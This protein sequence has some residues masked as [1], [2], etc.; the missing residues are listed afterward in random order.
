[1]ALR[2]TI[3]DSGKFDG[4]STRVVTITPMRAIRLFC[5]ECMGGSYREIAGCADKWCPLYL[6]RTGRK[7][8]DAVGG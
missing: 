2:H 7:P 6:Y 8:K 4:V 1:M 5:V 3:R